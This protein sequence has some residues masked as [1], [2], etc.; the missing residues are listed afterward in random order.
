MARTKSFDPTEVLEK[1]QRLFLA[2][3]F[4]GTSV[5]D[6]VNASG[7]SRSSLYDTFGD[8]EQ[9]FARSLANYRNHNTQLMIVKIQESTDIRQTIQEI[10]DY[11]REDARLQKKL[12]CLMV[13]TAIELAPHQKKISYLVAE[14]MNT[15]HATLTTALLQAQ[16][17][18]EISN[19][20]SP[21]S[22]ATLIITTVNGLRVAE[23]WGT[24][25]KTYQQV[26]QIVLNL[27]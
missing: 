19:R 6:L 18:N 10:Y 20:V 13:N 17:R 12:G 15:L 16:N 24:E 27:L 2:R 7:L 5:D 4:N 11:L 23:K 21:E 8:K 1:I 25:D 26:M 9:M 3:G 22:L 14:N